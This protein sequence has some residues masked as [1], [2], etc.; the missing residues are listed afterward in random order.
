MKNMKHR[1]LFCFTFFPF[2][3]YIES[4]NFFFFLK[5]SSLKNMNIFCFKSKYH[6]KKIRVMS[7]EESIVCSKKQ[8]K[9]W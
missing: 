2:K 3:F 1:T 9:V 8:L 5:Y 6:V 7:C 4:D